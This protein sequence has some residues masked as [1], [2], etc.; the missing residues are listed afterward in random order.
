MSNS[1]ELKR[2]LLISAA[3]IIQ[4]KID[5]LHARK[6][7]LGLIKYFHPEYIFNHVHQEIS[8]TLDKMERGEILNLLLLM[9][10]RHFKTEI[11][12]RYFPARIMGK[13]AN[14]QIMAISHTA[15]FAEKVGGEVRDII[16]NAKFKALYGISLTQSSHAK[17]L[18]TTSNGCEYGAY[19]VDGPMT[20][21][22]A[23]WLIMDDLHK[24]RL[25]A[26]SDLSRNG[27]INFYQSTVYPRL[28]PGARKVLAMQRW[29]EMDIAGFLKKEMQDGGER[30]HVIEYPAIN[31]KG[32]ALFPEW[33]SLEALTQIKNTI[34]SRAWSSQYQQQP[35]IEGGNI[36]QQGWFKYFEPDALGR[37]D[38]MI[39]SWDLKFSN[40][41][42]EGSYVVGQVWGRLGIDYYLL[43]QFRR[44]V[45]YTDTKRAIIE[46][47]KQWPDAKRKLVENK[48][49]GPALEDDLRTELTGIV[50]TEPD[51][52][53]K[54]RLYSV[55]PCMETGHVFLPNRPW[56][57]HDYIPE[58]IR[59]TGNKTEINDQVDCT[60][61]ALHYF[62]ER[63]G[64]ANSFRAITVS[65]KPETPST[66]KNFLNSD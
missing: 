54:A 47:S 46:L 31:E 34:G 50:L 59:F 45:G 44:R 30:W 37:L 16:S 48:A 49:N 19:G 55:T 25:E 36:V 39:Q 7:T 20:G 57:Q 27:V 65:N 14:Q 17:S 2:K 9:L 56:V 53:K 1:N 41:A 58:I 8:D 10:P 6:D 13:Y 5:R 21:A 35:N 43:D 29:H 42:N 18:L 38:E 15:T 22:G 26:D 60:S 28:M 66:P 63:K 51:G 40:K 33:F 62:E 32:E 3:E 11:V 23:H 61:Q 24:N 52:D 4:A 12:S 64:G